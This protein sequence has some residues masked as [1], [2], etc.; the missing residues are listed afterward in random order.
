MPAASRRLSIRSAREIEALHGL[1]RFTEADRAL[2][3]DGSPTERE[4]IEAV[5]PF[6]AAL[7]LALQLGDFKAKAQFFVYEGFRAQWNVKPG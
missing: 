3:F 4:A 6:S 2:Y 1:P 7:H 5:H